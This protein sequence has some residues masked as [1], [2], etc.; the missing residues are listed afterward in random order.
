MV[1]YDTGGRR[2][3]TA[4][5][6][7]V[8]ERRSV[9]DPMMTAAELIHRRALAYERRGDARGVGQV[10][11]TGN[12]MSRI[13]ALCFVRQRLAH[14]E[15]AAERFKELYE[16]LY[17]LGMPAVDTSRISVDNSIRAH[18]G[19]IAARLDRS[20]ALRDAQVLLGKQGFDRVVAC[21]VLGIPAGSDAPRMPSGKPNWRS[22]AKS[23]DRVLDALNEL[24]GLWGYQK[25]A[26]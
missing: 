5:D 9:D 14:H 7:I 13:G 8:I 25:S 16:S 20:A 15:R 21:I 24:A 23:V 22:A 10:E 26:A 11:A 19:G 12:A 6:H 3:P 2:I 17:G 1:M 18:D 4:A